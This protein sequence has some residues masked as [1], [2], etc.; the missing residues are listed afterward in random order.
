MTSVPR[1]CARCGG[2][3]P[4]ERV[5]ALPDTQVCIRCSSEM[6]GEFDVYV[7]SERISKDGSLKKNYGGYATKKVRKPI[8]PKE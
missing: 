3:I 8:R 6:G 7:V 4:A 2:E 5:E 1:P